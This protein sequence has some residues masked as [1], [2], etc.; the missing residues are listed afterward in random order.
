MSHVVMSAAQGFVIR[1]AFDCGST[2]TLFA[3]RTVRLHVFFITKKGQQHICYLPSRPVPQHGL[4]LL[5]VQL[6]TVK[7]WLP[8]VSLKLSKCGFD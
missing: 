6:I 7:N 8:F 1:S 5:G 4:L 3:S 2:L